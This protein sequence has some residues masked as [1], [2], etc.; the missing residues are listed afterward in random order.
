V[1]VLALIAC[2]MM[3]LSGCGQTRYYTPTGNATIT[4]NA[5]VGAVTNSTTLAVTVQ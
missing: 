3:A 5:T 2:S 1:L 4:I